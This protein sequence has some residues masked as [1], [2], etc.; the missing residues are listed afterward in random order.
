MNQSIMPCPPAGA[1]LYWP[2]N[3]APRDTA[4]YMERSVEALVDHQIA[5]R[6]GPFLQPKAYSHQCVRS[7]RT[8]YKLLFEFHNVALAVRGIS[9]AC[10]DRSK[11][12]IL[13]SIVPEKSVNGKIVSEP[14]VF[15]HSTAS[16]SLAHR[17]DILDDL[18]F[19]IQFVRHRKCPRYVFVSGVNE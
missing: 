18:R 13:V 1:G 8:T 4:S 16:L 14:F 5:V 19:I 10:A 11:P 7:A 15:S 17:E 2:P 6:N 12:G 3:P 9:V